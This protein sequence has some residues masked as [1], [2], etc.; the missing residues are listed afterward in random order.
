MVHLSTGAQALTQATFG[1]GTGSIL[2]DGV[3]C[4]GSERVLMNCTA[5]SSVSSSC[6]HAR[7]AGVRCSTG[8]VYRYSFLWQYHQIYF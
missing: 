6:T 3:Q 1:A 4:T 5:S 2:L 8:N 7:D